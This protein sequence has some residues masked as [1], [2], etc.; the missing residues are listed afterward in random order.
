M[1]SMRD[2]L[3]AVAAEFEVPAA[4]IRGRRK[5]QR[6]A[7]A[8]QAAMWMMRERLGVSF[9]R[10]GQLLR[11]DHSTVQH[12]VRAMAARIAADAD[13]AQAM[14]RVQQRLGVE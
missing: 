10:I 9:P 8:R 2:V 1:I 11:R 6:V 7:W 12:G 5:T 13:V 14:L 3:D 4:E